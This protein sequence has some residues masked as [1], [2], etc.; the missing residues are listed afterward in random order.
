[1]VNDGPFPAAP[2][3]PAG[4]EGVGVVIKVGREVTD[5]QEALAVASERPAGY[6]KG[7]LRLR[8]AAA[9]PGRIRFSVPIARDRIIPV[10]VDF[11]TA[12]CPH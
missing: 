7:V 5:V 1:M 2:D 4:H 3:T 6:I 8:N 11:P 10:V 9:A 12:F